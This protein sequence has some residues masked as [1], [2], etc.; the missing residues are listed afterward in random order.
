MDSKY[1][2][3]DLHGE[4]TVTAYTVVHN[5]LVEQ[6]ILEND[7]VKI[8]HGKGTGK[9][10]KAVQEILKKEEFV[11]N[12]YQNAFNLGETIVELDL[13]YKDKYK[14]NI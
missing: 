13:K 6:L 10:K 3:I 2:K 8:I 14:I 4:Y 12:Y 7:K 9:L 5:F 11:K 1:P